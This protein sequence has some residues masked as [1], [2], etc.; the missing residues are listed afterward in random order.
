VDDI[1][2]ASKDSGRADQIK[3]ELSQQFEIKGETKYCL[4]IEIRQEKK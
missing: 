2:V 1:L 4:G 3:K